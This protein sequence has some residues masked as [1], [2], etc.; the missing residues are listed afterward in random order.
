VKEVL[1]AAWERDGA[2]RGGFLDQAC[3][4]D[5]EL[6]REVEALL[7]SDEHGG[8]FLAAPAMVSGGIEQLSEDTSAGSDLTGTRGGALHHPRADR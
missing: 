4:H 2:E 6:R 3:A 1:E 7:V 5:P 8:E